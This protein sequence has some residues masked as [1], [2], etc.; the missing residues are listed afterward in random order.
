MKLRIS[1]LVAAGLLAAAIAVPRGT[2]AANKKLTIAFS[3]QDLE[4][5]FWVA[6]HKAIAETLAK[7]GFKVIEKNCS[8]DANL[9]LEQVKGLLTQNVDGVIIIPVDGELA[10]TI[11]KLANQAQVPYGVFNRPPSN[12]EAK[13]LVVVADNRKIAA[14]AVDY[15][16]QQAKKLGRKVTPAIMVGDL[17][18]PNAVG[19]R[20]GF[21]DIIEKYPDLWTGK[22]IEI[23][24]KWD[25]NVGLA[26]L[27]SAVQANPNIDFL[28]TSSDF[29]FPVIKSV[30]AP[31][32]KWEKSGNQ[33]HVIL[34]GLDGDK[35]ACGLIRD[36]Y[37]DSTGVQ[38]L[39][40]EAEM[41]TDAITAAV[42]AGEKTPEKWMDDHGFALTQANFKQRHL[43]MWGCR[44]LEGK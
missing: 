25:A 17:G 39:F 44:L 5:E 32:G 27:Q 1:L 14:D 18:D 26:N 10:V 19:R 42:S 6:G 16:A 35:T 40:A 2:H 3:F 24:T 4:T 20:Q 23:P 15:M 8:K 34:G 12:K 11:G 30:L 38:N 33:K 37:L 29:L 41:I 7:R 13:A 22:P 36:G 21:Y 28:F 31:L 9:Q 43:D